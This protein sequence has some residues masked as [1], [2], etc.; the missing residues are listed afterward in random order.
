MSLGAS[1]A[2]LC[3]D[4]LWNMEKGQ[5]INSFEEGCKQRAAFSF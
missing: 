2:T 1:P 5:Q 4:A 3:C